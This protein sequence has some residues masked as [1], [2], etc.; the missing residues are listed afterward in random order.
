MG[1]ERDERPPA[2]RR[3][4]IG[5]AARGIQSAQDMLDRT[6][7]DA[8]NDDQDDDDDQEAGDQHEAGGELGAEAPEVDADPEAA[9]EVVPAHPLPHIAP[10]PRAKGVKHPPVPTKTQVEKHALEQHINYAPWCTHCV[11]RPAH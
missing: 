10:R 11:S 9:P 3:F 6:G 8:R 2:V 7:R 1:G 4:L 5:A